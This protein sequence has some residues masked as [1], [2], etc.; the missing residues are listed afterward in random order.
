MYIFILVHEVM[1]FLKK[2][3]GKS[4]KS[5]GISFPDLCGNPGSLSQPLSMMLICLTSC[6]LFACWDDAG[7]WFKMYDI[8]RHHWLVGCFT[9]NQSKHL[10]HPLYYADCNCLSTAVQKHSMRMRI[11]ITM[12]YL[13]VAQSRIYFIGDEDKQ[14][15][16]VR[17]CLTIW[18]GYA[19]DQVTA[20]EAVF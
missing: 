6:Q 11:R 3:H 14:K 16:H 17:I 1:E 8:S 12:F 9:T 5:H 19:H 18:G 2:G 13:H 4:W 10:L 20:S 15:R 7:P